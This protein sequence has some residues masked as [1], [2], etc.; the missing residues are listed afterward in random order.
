MSMLCHVISCKVTLGQ[1]MSGRNRI[2]AFTSA[3]SCY[4][5]LREVS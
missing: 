1:L 5:R 3:L 2:D 4:F